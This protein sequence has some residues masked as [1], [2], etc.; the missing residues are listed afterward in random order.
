M[1]IALLV[2]GDYHQ[3]AERVG[4]KTALMAAKHLLK[5]KQVMNPSLK[6]VSFDMINVRVIF[7][8]PFSLAFVKGQ[9]GMGTLCFN[10]KGEQ[11]NAPS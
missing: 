4:A 7:L 11:V 1:L 10:C 9:T 5:G 8:D 6:A 3:G 2:G